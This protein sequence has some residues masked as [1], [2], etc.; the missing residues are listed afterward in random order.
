LVSLT[1]SNIDNINHRILQRIESLWLKAKPWHPFLEALRQALFIDEDSLNPTGTKERPSWFLL[2]ILCSQA[3]GGDPKLAEDIAAAWALLYTSA[4]I[5]D[6]IED[7]EPYSWIKVAGKGP[8]INIATGLIISAFGV[9]NSAQYTTLMGEIAA[10]ITADFQQTI[11]QICGGQHRD[12]T[13]RESSLDECWSI[14]EKKSGSS[15]ALACRAGARLA[16]NDQS[17]IDCYSS[18]GRHLGMMIQIGD[19]VAGIWI[20]KGEK[21]DITS[22]DHWTLPIAYAMEVASVED[23]ILLLECL[24]AG[25]NKHERVSK[26]LDLLER[27]GAP[28]YL[29]T[30]MEWHRSEAENSLFNANPEPSA[31][32]SLLGLLNYIYLMPSAPSNEL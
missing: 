18:F 3:A 9:L 15:F 7:E 4:H 14:A 23:Q 19:D 31:R 28:L 26:A 22:G 5:L 21:S 12:L 30:K 13:C 24:N 8:S 2:P 6:K 25:Y 16:T 17:K 11:L 29:A 27:I 32:D 20:A 10:E 1:I